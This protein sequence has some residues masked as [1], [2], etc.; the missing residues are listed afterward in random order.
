MA[1][2]GRRADHAHAG[3]D[4]LHLE[5]SRQRHAGGVGLRHIQADRFIQAV[6]AQRAE[7]RLGC[8]RVV[9]EKGPDLV[10]VAAA[11]DEPV[12]LDAAVIDQRQRP[13]TRLRNPPAEKALAARREVPCVIV[14]QGGEVHF[15]GGR[16]DRRLGKSLLR[17]EGEPG[18]GVSAAIAQ[19]LIAIDHVQDP[20]QPGVAFS[21]MF[22]PCAREPQAKAATAM[23]RIDD[24]QPTES[25]MRVVPQSRAPGDDPAGQLARE[26]A[27]RVDLPEAIGVVQ[28]RVPAFLGG[29]L[30]CVVHLRSRHGANPILVH[31]EALPEPWIA[32]GRRL[33]SCG[34][35]AYGVTP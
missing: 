11:T 28:A 22:Q 26:E 19:A 12:A 35:L 32:A 10:A 8:L 4:R 6:V 33:G 27:P 29:A 15:G 34:S 30:D 5:A 31:R 7:K 21:D 3:K 2:R 23:S 16:Q 14:G 9:G 24:V 18:G 25:E 13:G 20:I 17:R 1:D